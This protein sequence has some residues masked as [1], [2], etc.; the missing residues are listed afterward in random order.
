MLIP[1][2]MADRSHCFSTTLYLLCDAHHGTLHEFRLEHIA[3]TTMVRLEIC[4]YTDA[5]VT[6]EARTCSG[7][8]CPEKGERHCCGMP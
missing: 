8:V 5:P 3:D 1:W 2:R 6:I 7:L 4:H